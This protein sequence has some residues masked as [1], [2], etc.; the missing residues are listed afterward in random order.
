MKGKISSKGK[1]K[2]SHV[3]DEV[4]GRYS[5]NLEEV[6]ADIE[7]IRKHVKPLP[8]GVTVKDLIEEGRT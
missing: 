6:F 2:A 1:R 4:R 3:T 8:K 7:R 5:V